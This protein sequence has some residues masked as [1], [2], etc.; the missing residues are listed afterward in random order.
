MTKRGKRKGGCT[1]KHA[2]A[3]LISLWQQEY[4][5]DWCGRLLAPTPTPNYAC[6]EFF[7]EINFHLRSMCIHTHTH[8]CYT[9]FWYALVRLPAPQRC[10]AYIHCGISQVRC[11]SSSL[12]NHLSI[13][14]SGYGVCVC[15]RTV[16]GIGFKRAPYRRRLPINYIFELSVRVVETTNFRIEIEIIWWVCNEVNMLKSSQTH[17]PYS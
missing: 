16:N 5:F 6:T 13:K 10:F 2:Y 14:A 7:D 1:T 17:V 12:F 8:W 3:I 4:A 15:V 11:P 9:E